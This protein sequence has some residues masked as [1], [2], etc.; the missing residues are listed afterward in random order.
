MAGLR[1]VLAALCAGMIAAPGWAA[2]IVIAV[3][4]GI[5]I[6]DS[7][8]IY[9]C[10]GGQVSVRYI[11]AGTVSL[12]VFE[13]DGD[14]IVASNVVSA[15]GARYAGGRYVWWSKGE[16]ATLEDLMAESDDALINCEV[17]VP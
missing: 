6:D 3:P 2:D 10:P 8:H 9:D 11:N 17:P 13:W 1:V 14:Q 4:D 12:A 7:T 15:S 16:E 5:A